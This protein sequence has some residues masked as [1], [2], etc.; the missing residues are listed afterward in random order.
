MWGGT[1]TTH[2]VQQM[3]NR[4]PG[5]NR[6]KPQRAAQRALVETMLISRPRLSVT[7]VAGELGVDKGTIS[8]D[9][10]AIKKS[11]GTAISDDEKRV[12]AGRELVVIEHVRGEALIGWQKSLQPKK[13]EHVAERTTEAVVGSQHLEVVGG[14]DDGKQVERP[15]T[16]PTGTQ[17]LKELRTQEGAGDPRF[18]TV[19][20]HATDKLIAL[21]GLAEPTRLQLGTAPG[22]MAALIEALAP[23]PLARQAAAAALW[24]HD[25]DELDPDDDVNA[26]PW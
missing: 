7:A 21:L 4:Q 2:K 22:D 11:W 10:T 14:A 24:G 17:T 1:G 23:Y 8:R 6:S 18:L 13:A 25:G 3:T 19:A 15:I 20:L 9:I 5:Q 26:L 12:L 16:K